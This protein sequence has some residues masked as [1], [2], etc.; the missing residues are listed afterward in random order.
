MKVKKIETI[1]T[2]IDIT[3]TGAR[4]LTKEEAETL[5][6]RLRLY[7]DWWWTSS[8]DT[9]GFSVFVVNGFFRCVYFSPVDYNLTVR[10]ALIFKSV[11]LKIGDCINVAGLKF[12]IIEEGIA[13]CL[14]DIGKCEFR[15]DWEAEDA[16]QYEASDIKKFVEQWFKENIK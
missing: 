3:F 11:E 16:N 10:P 5:P 1:E 4:L 15:K 2:P 12:E 13:L 14:S 6:E 8:A 7:N 9:F